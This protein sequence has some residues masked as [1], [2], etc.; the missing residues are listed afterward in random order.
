[1]KTFIMLL[2]FLPAL[3]LSAQNSAA[4]PLLVCGVDEVFL[5]DSAAAEKGTLQKLWSWRAKDREELPEA[6]RKTFATTD[7]CK[8]VADGTKI[9]ISSSSGGCALVEWPGGRVLWH[10]RVANAHSI[11][12]L[13]QDR[14]VVAASVSAQGNKLVV[15]DLAKS[16]EPVC[17]TP[18][19]S[20]HGVVW[21]ESRHC[22]WALGFSELRRYE[23]KGWEGGTPSLALVASHPLPDEDGHD[24]QAVPGSSDLVLSTDHHVYLFDRDKP[25]FHL[26]PR[27]GE[28]GHAKCVSTHPTTGRVAFIHGNDKA[29]WSGVIGFLAPQGEAKLGA[30]RVYK[31]RWLPQAKADTRGRTV[32][33]ISSANATALVDT[34]DTPDLKDWGNKAGT[35][36]VEWF[37]KIAALLPSEGFTAP[38]EVTLFFD[39]K[40]EGVAHASG[41]RIAI[42]AG[43]VRAHP[44]DFGMVVHELTHVVQ[45]YPPGAPV[46]L[47][48]GV[49]DYIRIVHYEP[50]APRP[51]IDPAKASHKDA[52]KTTGMF[53][54]WV[55]KNHDAGFVARV[56]AA[57]RQ[58]KYDDALWSKWTGKSVDELWKLF[59]QTLPAVP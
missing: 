57:L 53:L 55:E 25:A 47:M 8:P 44:D 31:A 56:N 30:E 38:K 45:S 7:E 15:F 46:W 29:W 33:K 50:K 5:I 20:A 58:G 24:L 41:A 32:T 51:Q 39:P 37:P 40:M 36:C 17:E 2:W 21:D 1:M 14:V 4:Q 19:P 22:L 34:N 48:E 9:L 27:L 43:W 26:H 16:N 12:L 52:Y 23:L 6:L 10:A 18:L 54:E 13:P 42:A 3:C 11:E 59:T 49:A 35:L 28:V